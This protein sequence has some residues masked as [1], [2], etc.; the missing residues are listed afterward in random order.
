[1]TAPQATFMSKFV[2]KF[3]LVRLGVGVL[4]LNLVVVLMAVV[5]LRQSWHNRQD[6]AL[7]TAHN[8]ALVLDQYVAD[9]FAKADL[10]VW[11][12]KDEIEHTL[13][14]NGGGRRDLDGF[15][16]RQYERVPWLQALRATDAQGS[17]VYESGAGMG[18]TANLADRDYFIRLRDVPD[19]GLVISKPLIGKVTGKWL[20]V[21]ARRIEGPNRAF[22]GIVYAVITLAEFDKALSA[23]DVGPHGS[24]SIRDLDLGLVLRHPEPLSAGT[25]VGQKVVSPELV[26]FA[27]SGRGD[28]NYQALTP[29]DRVRRTFSIRKVAGLPFYL[30]VGLAEQDYMAAWKKQAFQEFIEVLLFACLA[31]AASWLIHRAWVRQKADQQALES[32]LAEVKSLGNMVPICSHCKKIRDD[33]GYWNQ[34]EAYLNE[35]IDAEFTHGICPDC[36][37]EAFPKSSTRPTTIPS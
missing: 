18:S 34:I 12:V 8:L 35:H 2:P 15:I 30:L 3:F 10:A 27:K 7:S 24:V 4:V 16:R 22:M 6:Q 32:L 9:T 1:M 21:M 37:R 33:R 11:A 14:S 5:S 29:F 20:I 31:L 25:A 36:A 28:G 23:L 17:I 19:A 13:A 26:A